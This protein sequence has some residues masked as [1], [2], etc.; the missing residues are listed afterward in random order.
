MSETT[1]QDGIGHP[2][3]LDRLWNPHRMAYVRGESKP[4]DDSEGECPF[5]RIPTL[6]D[7]TGLVV[8]RGELVFAV[9][10]LY[11][12]APGHLMVCPYRHIADY[13]ETTP[14]E[15]EEMSVVTK[16]ALH[17]L[18]KVSN[19]QGR[20]RRGDRRAPAPARRA[21]VARRPELHAGDRE[22]QDAAGAAAGHPAPARRVV[23]RA[24]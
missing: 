16:Q 20:R 18:R 23:G 13:T 22:D 19:V 12:Y 21:T 2:D 9:L 4:T 5:C 10:N 7:E 1:R 6:D 3:A 8:H 15:A 24:P 11:P 14:E 17:T